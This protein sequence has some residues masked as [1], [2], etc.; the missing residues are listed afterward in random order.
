M[1]LF[2]QTSDFESGLLCIATDNYSKPTLQSIIDEVEEKC[3]QEL[4]GCD[5]YNL[6][7]ADYTTANP[8]STAFS[9]QRFIDLFDSFCIDNNCGIISSDGIKKMLMYFIFVEHIRFQEVNNAL[10]GNKEVDTESMTNVHG[11][12]LFVHYNRAIHTYSA[13]QWLICDTSDL[14]PEYNGQIKELMGWL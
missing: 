7:I 5:L 9:E 4:L 6:F 3:L 8:S 13:I 11:K 2:V 1:S 14:Y 12:G 10:S